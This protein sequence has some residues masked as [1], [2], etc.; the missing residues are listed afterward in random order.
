MIC[1]TV[2]TLEMNVISSELFAY[3]RKIPEGYLFSMSELS[4]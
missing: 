4:K 3:V 1:A 2:M